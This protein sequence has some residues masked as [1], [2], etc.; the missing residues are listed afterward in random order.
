MSGWRSRNSFAIISTSRVFVPLPSERKFA[1]WIAGP[2]A[3]GS[4]NGIPSSIT[5]APP[6]TSASRLAAVSPSPA[7][8]K[9]TSAG[10]PFVKADARRVIGWASPPPGGGGER[11]LH[12]RNNLV[13]P[14][15]HTVHVLHHFVVGEP[16]DPVASAL[17][18]A[19]AG[20]VI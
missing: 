7:V 19:S 13:Q 11:G 18:K 20:G 5:S 17:Q 4:V 10:R 3:I 14:D 12:S 15:Q 6:S 9:H 2:S 1:A 8:M 16:Q